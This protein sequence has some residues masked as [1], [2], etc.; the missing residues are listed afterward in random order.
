[1]LYTLPEVAGLCGV[2]YRTLH[3]WMARGLLRVTREADGS[4]KPAMFSHDDL[5]F[6]EVLTR[7]RTFGLSMGGLEKVARDWAP[8]SDGIVFEIGP[9]LTLVIEP[10]LT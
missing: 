5:R 9:G 7:L 10:K 1:M 6:A 3:S 4:G 8:L 2:E